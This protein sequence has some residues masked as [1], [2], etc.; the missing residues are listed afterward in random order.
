M[1]SRALGSNTNPKAQLVPPPQVI[2]GPYW[3]PTHV[4]AAAGLLPRYGVVGTD[5][6]CFVGSST[7]A[8]LRLAPQDLA[9]FSAQD[10]VV[11]LACFI[12]VG[13]IELISQRDT[14]FVHE[15]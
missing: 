13:G 4:G 9:I 8:N 1:E 3:F 15:K 7:T 5:L 10:I 11:S 6:M 14:R 12:R 2:G